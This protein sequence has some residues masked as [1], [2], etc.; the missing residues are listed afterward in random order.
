MY[1]IYK[2]NFVF[3]YFADFSVRHIRG[4]RSRNKRDFSTELKNTMLNV[5]LLSLLKSGDFCE[6]SNTMFSSG[7]SSTFLFT[8]R[9]KFVDYSLLYI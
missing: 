8:D 1:D 2:I 9:G 5:T 6:D 3:P 4:Q 7:N